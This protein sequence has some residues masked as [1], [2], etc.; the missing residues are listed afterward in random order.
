MVYGEQ[1]FQSFAALLKPKQSFSEFVAATVITQKI[2][3][4]S[5]AFKH[6]N[7]RDPEVSVESNS[8][9]IDPIG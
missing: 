2:G 6:A 8:S 5:L 9:H 3:P 4:A 7:R 1:G